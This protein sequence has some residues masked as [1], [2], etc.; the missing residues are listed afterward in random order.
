[1]RWI[2]YLPLLLLSGCSSGDSSSG[3]GGANEE[4]REV[5]ALIEPYQNYVRKWIVGYTRGE[6]TGVYVTGPKTGVFQMGNFWDGMDDTWRKASLVH[7]ACHMEHGDRGCNPA[8][9][10]RCNAYGAAYLKDA[11]HASLSETWLRLDG[12]H[13]G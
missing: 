10:R 7:D 2:P 13:C 4:P 8:N 3:T 11:G 9:E 1:M 6:P 5:A 12:E